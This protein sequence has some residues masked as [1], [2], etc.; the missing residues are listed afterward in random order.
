[1]EILSVPWRILILPLEF[2]AAARAEVRKH[3][4]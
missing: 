2:D 1:M 4:R 3:R